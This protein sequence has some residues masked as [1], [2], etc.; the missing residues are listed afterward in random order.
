MAS[1]ATV[2]S[3]ITVA[4]ASKPG[5]D[6]K[7]ATAGTHHVVVY[8]G[9]VKGKHM[10]AHASGGHKWPDAIRYEPMNSK[11]YSSSGSYHYWYTHGIILRPWDLARADKEA[12]LKNQKDTNKTPP[13]DIVDDPDEVTYEVTF[14]GLDG[15][16]PGDFVSSGNLVTNVTV[17][18]TTDKTAYPKTVSHVLLLSLIH[19]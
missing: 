8:C 14:K 1:N 4:W 16:S 13:K 3:N 10:I 2:P 18:N 12:K 11:H 9:K 15:S 6:S 19:I 7:R 5:G 17:N